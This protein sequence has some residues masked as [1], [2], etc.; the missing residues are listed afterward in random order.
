MKTK[1]REFKSSVNIKFDLGKQEFFR[2]YLPTPSH[3]ESLQKII[4]GFNDSEGKH[5][6]IVIGPYGTGKSLLGT[7]IAGMA[8][9]TVSD[10]S[11]EFLKKKF[12]NVDDEIYGQLSEFQLK[13]KKYL[14]VILNGN[15]GSFRQSI[16][17]AIMKT[18]EENNLEIIIP[19][20]INK[21]L[22]TVEKWEEEFPK[23]YKEFKKQLRDSERSIDVWR[24]NI[25]NYEKEEIAWFKNIFP[26]LSSGAEFIV[27]FKE[28]FTEQIK[29]VIDQLDKQN[30]GLFIV[31]DEFGRFLQSLQPN[32]IHETMQDLQ[33]LAELSDHH[34]KHLHLLFITHKNLRHY[35][36]K[37]SE[38]YQ[39]EFQ[40][41]EK[42]FQL[43]HI[44]SDRST[45]I[46]ITES[47]LSKMEQKR[48]IPNLTE[49]DV[50][51]ELRKYPLFSHLNQVEIEKLVIKG[52]YPIHPVAIFML[53]HLSSYFAQ[54]ERTLFTFLQSKEKGGL[55]NHIKHNTGYYLTYKLF[56][57]FFPEIDQEEYVENKGLEIYKKLVPRIPIDKNE[58]KNLF[59]FLSLWSITN[60]SS[61][62]KL[63]SDFISFAMSLEKELVENQLLQL[64]KLKVIRFNRIQG[65]WELFEGSSID[66]D[67]E[68]LLRKETSTITS[69][70]KKGILEKT[71]NRKYFLSNDYNDQ[72]SMTR[73]AS[74][75]I[76][77]S[78]EI[79]DANFDSSKIRFEMNSDAIVNYVLIEDTQE[80]EIVIE[81]LA[82]INDKYS[83][84]CIPFKSIQEVKEE[85]FQYHILTTLKQD[86][87]FMKN[88]KDL[89]NEVTI[90]LEDV[91]YT[92]TNFM[93]TYT[94]FSG[95]LQ[96][97][98]NGKKLQ[99]KN[100]IIFEKILSNRMFEI[101][102][103]TPEVR[104]DSFVRRKINSVQR[105]AGFKVV[106]HIIE[107]YNEGGLAI[108]GNGPDYLIYAT[109][110]KNN[111]LDLS[112]LNEIE[113]IEFNSLRNDLVSEL[114]RKDQGKLS[115]LT[116]ILKLEPYGI[117]APLIPIILISLL[118]DK[119]DQ[120]M[121]YRNEM[122][123]PAIT[124]EKL[125]QMVEEDTEYE[126]AFY[127]F[128]EKYK[129]LF[130]F[131][132]E[133]FGEYVSETA[134]R[135]ATPIVLSS[136]LLNWLRSLPRFTQV[137]N[138]M[139]KELVEFR[140]LIKRSEIDPRSTIELFY[141]N[142]AS[143]LSAI[144]RN[145]ESLESHLLDYKK[146]LKNR[147]L[148][149]IGCNEFIELFQ[150]ANKKNPVIKKNNSLVNGIINADRDNWIDSIILTIVGVRLEE[151]SD[152]TDH[153]FEQLLLKDYNSIESDIPQGEYLTISLNGS[154][155]SIT[156]LEMSTK[157][158][159]I[160]KNVH[161]MIKNA[162]RNVP[163]DEIEYMV[164][165]LV[166]E[167]V[168]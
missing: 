2:N 158:Q 47:L 65:S 149:L 165:H 139:N 86:A 142:Y 164:Y 84:F 105:K 53:P 58:L 112:N 144:N 136:G 85:L 78:S 6:H 126:F 22:K 120:L 138:N 128:D 62:Q 111:N 24:V 81:K 156:K 119:W 34:A 100:E 143:N 14:P 5:S 71:L 91:F 23:T 107:D 27:D 82:S 50:K 163:K 40:R 49:T 30:L 80:Y 64:S 28:D 72:K 132:K 141:L 93:K 109:I 146:V 43:Y 31:Y 74:V 75:N 20:I 17:S 133:T 70:Q 63:T 37:L 135:S 161:R 88:D 68:I 124:G 57:F 25:L 137:T 108:E 67:H 44:D 140:D 96:W 15:E 130:N 76:I 21:I 134:L 117:R 115:D 46:R 79:L 99:I 122:Y 42:R 26:S 101:F 97:Y 29:F 3:A 51:N 94:E 13:D 102:P 32:M 48:E 159:T 160:Y 98:L 153:M 59:K 18:I 95:E 61:K 162:G 11:F 116:Q 55:V 7:L 8:S 41:I 118:R 90:K 33:D 167:F 83:Y 16:I 127:N 155:K 145:K 152:T 123:V 166:K 113:S 9:R 56:D 77:L 19:G 104:N 150:W 129:P 69:N 39:N 38:E 114:L 54:N 73:F 35:F 87:D 1:R 4:A 154:E 131:L 106:D 103:L 168:E 12:T 10:S 36:L 60:L 66:L 148:N 45:F 157:T 151:W 125:Y 121:F 92:L 110:F 147:V 52:A 89:L